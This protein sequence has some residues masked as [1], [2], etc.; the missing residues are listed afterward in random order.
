[1]GVPISVI[2]AGLALLTSEKGR[3]TVG[4]TLAAVLSPV[5]LLVAALCCLA[6]GAAEHNSA[7]A[8]L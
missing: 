2:K 8:D 4:W 3:K 6:S 1:M 5:I 7:A